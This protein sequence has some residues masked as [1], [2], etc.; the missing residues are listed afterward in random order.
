MKEFKHS[1]HAHC[2]SGVMSSMLSHH[3]FKISEPMVFGLSNALNFAYIPFV[4]IGGMPLVAYRSLPKSIIKN[5]KKNLKIDIKMETF[6]SQEK[7]E[8]R[9]DELLDEGKIVGVQGSVYWLDYFPDELR[10]HFN[11]HNFLIYG[12]E[13]DN[14]LVSDPVFQDVVKCSKKS[15]SKSRFSKGVMAPKGLLYYPEYIPK[16]IDFKSIITKNIKKLSKNMLRTPVPIAGLKGLR[17]LAKGILK[18]RSRDKK[19]A[20]LFLGNIVRMQEEIGT[21]G[22]GFRF[23]YASF[24]EESSELFDGNEV[25]SDAS[26]MMLEV[27]DEYREF[28]LV[29]AKS[30]KSKKEIDFEKISDMLFKIGEHEA[31]V[32]KK[33]LEFKA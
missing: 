9:L 27:G 1:H 25:L 6:S 12:K 18:L 29:I 11:A 20:K 32:Y 7:G 24:L 31:K 30:I 23:M 21:G 5:I 28:A 26:K 13:E 3:G 2:E 14:Y 10:F 17:Y 15:L 4:K 16:N 19:Y 8:N 33:L 22:A